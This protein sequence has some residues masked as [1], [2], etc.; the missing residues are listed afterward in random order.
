M[1]TRKQLLKGLG[2]V[3][4]FMVLSCSGN[5]ENE[6][7]QEQPF[8][9]EYFIRFEANGTLEEYNWDNEK[10]VFVHGAINSVEE[11][12]N[13]WLSNG[14]LS[15]GITIHFLTTTPIVSGYTYEQEDFDW[16]NT[17]YLKDGEA[18]FGNDLKV[19]IEDFGN[20]ESK[21]EFSGTFTNTDEEVVS[22][23]NGEFFV[24]LTTNN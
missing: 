20:S 14:S 10:R 15:K 12:G 17:I 6:M 24:L 18:Y 22:I 16:N 3:I 11:G 21:G 5:D 9:N 7:Q 19:F 13:F 4:L 23:T 2:L 1:E 8:E